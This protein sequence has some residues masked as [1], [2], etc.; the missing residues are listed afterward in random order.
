MSLRRLLLLMLVGGFALTGC[1]D[2]LVDEPLQAEPPPSEPTA[3]ENAIYL[4]GP[5]ALQIGATGNYRAEPVE[6][7]VRYDWAQTSINNGEVSGVSTDPRLRL[8]ELTGVS[9]GTVRLSVQALDAE[10]HVIGIGT[11]T[12]LVGQ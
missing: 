7:A 12:V 2:A 6:G 10:N 11:K 3:Q 8:F 9:S 1:R 5:A 4:K